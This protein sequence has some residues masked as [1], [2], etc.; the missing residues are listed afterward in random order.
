[1]TE[2]KRYNLRCF[3][4]NAHHSLDYQ[5][6]N[7]EKC[8]GL[9]EVK[10]DLTMK[11]RP[12]V[13]RP[14]S[15]WRY[16]ELLPVEKYRS[17]VSL[18]EGG[19]GLHYCRRLGKKLGL[20]KLR[21]KNEGE[22][23][24]GSFKDRGMTVAVS[25]AVELRKK[26]VIC[27]STG[28]TGASLAAYSAKAGLNCM[29]LVPRGKV[30]PGKM[31]QVIIH[32][33]RVVQVKG[34]FDQALDSV[35]RLTKEH[36]GLYL[37]NS[38]NPF[39]LEGQKTLAYEITDQLAG[40]APDFVILPVGN[41]GNIS[42]AWKGFGEFRELGMTRGTPRMV[43]IQAEKSA[44]IVRAIRRREVRLTPLQNP[45]T[46]ATAIRI[47]SPVNWAK[48]LRAIRE[49][50]G[51]AESVT[52]EEILEAQRDLARY[53]GIFV[54]PA[55]AAPVAGITRMIKNGTIDRSDLVVCVATGHGL[56]DPS[57]ADRI[58]RSSPT[59][60]VEYGVSLSR[61]VERIS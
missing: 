43:G 47:G 48:V 9:L 2:G 37:M 49:S 51:I 53:E 45:E 39:R 4:C 41:G 57:I 5:G 61:T 52:D 6:F 42:A 44:P 55:G 36:K 58:A 25:R 23:P 18:G 56:K 3:E 26:T 17:V 31:V 54:E 28:N 33:A 8:G 38:L 59:F 30:A 21:I 22:N 50:K 24:T 13:H 15:V 20:R 7:C 40:I 1:M 10:F 35:I 29:V 34:N 27:A 46:I 60:D 32:G 14:L 16:E 12:W 19:T 11:T